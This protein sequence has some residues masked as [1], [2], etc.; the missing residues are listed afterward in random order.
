M[1]T[2]KIIINENREIFEIPNILSDSEI[3]KYLGELIK[4]EIQF[5]YNGDY[6]MVMDSIDKQKELVDSVREYECNPIKIAKDIVEKM[7][8]NAKINFDN[9][10][11]V[12]DTDFKKVGDICFAFGLELRHA[13]NGLSGTDF[14]LSVK[15]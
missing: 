6:L 14:E 1:K 4:E 12:I 2:L 5:E 7:N 13:Y 10:I 9:N 15:K 3:Q 11:D 8:V